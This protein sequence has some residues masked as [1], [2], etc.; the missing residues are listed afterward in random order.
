MGAIA[1]PVMVAFNET[2]RIC[3]DVGKDNEPVLALALSIKF[4]IPDLVN[5]LM[6]FQQKHDPAM[7]PVPE[8]VSTSWLEALGIQESLEAWP[9]IPAP[10][11]LPHTELWVSRTPVTG[12]VVGAENRHTLD[13][14]R[15]CHR[16]TPSEDTWTLDDDSC[17]RNLVP[18]PLEPPRFGRPVSR[19]QRPPAKPPPAAA[20]TTPQPTT[21]PP[22][23]AAVATSQPECGS[24]S[25]SGKPTSQAAATTQPKAADTGLPEAAATPQ[26]VAAVAATAP[27]SAA[28]AAAQQECP[29]GKDCPQQ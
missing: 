4:S 20:A 24:A 19:R 10:D 13:E 1:V 9:D 26:P 15:A 14:Y 27:Q 22:P 23:A 21:K 8:K 6:R 17:L 12:P 5:G 2:S 11:M 29:E 28:R 3:F 7:K 16:W 25:S 18:K